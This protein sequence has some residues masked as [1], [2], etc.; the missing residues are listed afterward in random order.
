MVEIEW[1]IIRMADSV[2]LSKVVTLHVLLCFRATRLLYL[3][4]YGAILYELIM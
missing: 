4:F 2:S 1:E 3:V